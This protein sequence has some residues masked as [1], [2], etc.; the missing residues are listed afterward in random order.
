MKDSSFSLPNN[1][2]WDF[3]LVSFDTTSLKIVSNTYPGI[4][5][6]QFEPELVTF[7]RLGYPYTVF[8]I[9][10]GK[11]LD[12]RYNLSKKLSSFDKEWLVLP[13]TPLQFAGHT[14]SSGILDGAYISVEKYRINRSQWERYNTIT[15]E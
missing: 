6:C 4:Y 2:L 13:A 3:A 11:V 10:A 1:E 8:F 9:N 7:K 5:E 14:E 12:H 15:Y